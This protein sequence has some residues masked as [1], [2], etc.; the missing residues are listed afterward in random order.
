MLDSA[1][2]DGSICFPHLSHMNYVKWAMC[3]EAVLVCQGATLILGVEDAQLA[4]MTDS[5]PYTIWENLAKV[6]CTDGFGSC[7]ALHHA[8]ITASVKEGQ[9][10]EAWIGEVHFLTNCLTA[11]DIST[12]DEDIIIVLTA[13]LPPY[14]TIIISLNAIKPE[15]L[16]LNFVITCLLNEES[17]QN[18]TSTTTTAT[19]LE[20]EGEK[21]ALDAMAAIK[22]TGSTGTC[23]YCR[24]IG[25]FTASCETRLK[26]FKLI[27]KKFAGFAF[28]PKDEEENYAF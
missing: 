20:S 7:L 21:P 4:H 11:I 19:T 12:P 5:N 13:G 14:E 28:F 8:F 6:H 9:T 27:D 17:C 24:G 16:T 18:L 25:H 23:F 26:H 3:M 1:P 22:K 2:T 10:M 15:E